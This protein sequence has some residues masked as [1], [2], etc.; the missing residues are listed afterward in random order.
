MCSLI[1]HGAN[2]RIAVVIYAVVDCGLEAVVAVLNAMALVSGADAV[3]GRI[4]WYAYWL[5]AWTLAMV[6][7][8]VL[9]FRGA[10]RKVSSESRMD[11]NKM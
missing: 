10:H 2:A 6:A 8:D 11:D 4:V 7:A 5:P 1:C 9:L 3:D